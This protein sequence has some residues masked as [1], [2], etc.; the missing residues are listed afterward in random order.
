MV[1]VFR[2]AE[3]AHRDNLPVKLSLDMISS[4]LCLS[5]V[6]LI[7]ILSLYRLRLCREERCDTELVLW[8]SSKGN[9]NTVSDNGVLSEPNS[10]NKNVQRQIVKNI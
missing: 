5:S 7:V 4:R 8:R 10:W 1:S 6:A 9:V 2:N 3:R